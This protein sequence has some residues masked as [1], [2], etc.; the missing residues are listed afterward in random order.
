MMEP[1]RKGARQPAG[2]KKL[3]KLAE[4][5]MDGKRGGG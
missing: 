2:K 1:L 5:M 3:G 4:K